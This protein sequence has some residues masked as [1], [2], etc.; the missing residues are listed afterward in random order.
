MKKIV[1]F[2]LAFILCLT[3]GIIIV[4]SNCAAVFA[5]EIKNADA[6]KSLNSVSNAQTTVVTIGY[7]NDN[8]PR[9][10]NGFTD[11][12]RKSGYAYEYFQMLAPFVGWKY[13]Y[14]YGTKAEI[15]QKLIDGEVDIMAGAY[16]PTYDV[17]IGYDLST[18]DMGLN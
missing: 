17:D 18:A 8:E 5:E 13:E 11:D 4:D 14:E 6:D 15:L 7:Y 9:F 12:V 2:I 10:Q 3:S 1:I 16:K